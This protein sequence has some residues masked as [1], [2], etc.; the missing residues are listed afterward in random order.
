MLARLWRKVFVTQYLV[1]DLVS[2]ARHLTN[3]STTT[4]QLIW[5]LTDYRPVQ[6]FAVGLLDWFLKVC[7]HRR[8]GIGR[9]HR[10]V[11]K[12]CVQDIDF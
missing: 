6:N 10:T 12:F 7:F 4:R 8:S 3:D 2:T 11:T 1:Q 9:I 5:N